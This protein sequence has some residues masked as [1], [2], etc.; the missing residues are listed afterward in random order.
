[1]S[2]A[3]FSSL[4]FFSYSA[5]F[6]PPF[7]EVRD[8]RDVPVPLLRPPENLFHSTRGEEGGEEETVGP[9]GLHEAKPW[10]THIPHI[11]FHPGRR[12]EEEEKC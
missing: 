1:M 3:G 5:Q 10:L 2:P 7:A 11:R 8:G 9:Y 6:R 4:F 12:G